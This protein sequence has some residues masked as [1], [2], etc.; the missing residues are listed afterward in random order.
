MWT[1]LIPLFLSD[2]SS[3]GLHNIG[4]VHFFLSNSKDDKWSSVDGDNAMLD[5]P[6]GLQSGARFGFAVNNSEKKIITVN[7]KLKKIF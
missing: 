2:P 6:A 5:T 3:E 7:Y 4:R 1:C